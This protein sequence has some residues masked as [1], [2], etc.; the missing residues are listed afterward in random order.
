LKILI[1]NFGCSSDK[2][3]DT[4]WKSAIKHDIKLAVTLHHLAKGA[5][6]TPMAFHYRLGKSTVHGILNDR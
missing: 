2:K 3:K 1:I 6:L 4:S 5:S